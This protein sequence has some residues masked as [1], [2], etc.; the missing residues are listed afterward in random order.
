MIIVMNFRYY[1]YCYDD[2]YVEFFVMGLSC[3]EGGA[4]CGVRGETGRAGYRASALAL[5]QLTFMI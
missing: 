1:N 5:F 2:V 4:R 3:S